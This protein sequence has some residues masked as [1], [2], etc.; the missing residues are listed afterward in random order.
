M[1]K[2]STTTAATANP[3]P[4]P[5]ASRA[6][7]PADTDL[8]LREDIRFLGRLLGDTIREQAGERIFTIVENIRRTAV[9]YRREHDPRSLRTVEKT[10]AALD[11]DAATHVVRAFSYFHHLANVAEDQHQNRRRR[12]GQLA[13]DQPAKPG[14]LTFALQRLRAAQVPTRKMVAF[15]EKACVEPVLTAHPT[16]VQRKSIL[17][18]HRSIGAQLASRD[19]Q[20]GSPALL[21][22]IEREMRREIL[23]LWKTSEV[24]AVKPTVA[25]EIENGLAY[26]RSTFLKVIPKI[27]ADLE[28]ALGRGVNVGPFLRVSSWIGG[29]RDGNPHVTH[30]VTAL[31]LKRQA[32][33]IL[34]H[35]LGE[36]HALG[37]ELSLSSRYADVPPELVALAALSPDRAVTR[38]QEPFRRALIGIYA[39]LAATARRLSAVTPALYGAVGPAEPYASPGE[40][41]SDLDVIGLALSNDGAEL[42]AEGRLRRLRRAAEVFGFHLSSLD[43]RQHSAVHAR[44]VREI[45][46]R[47]IGR[48]TYETLSEPERQQLLLHELGTPRPL[49]SPHITYSNE[50]TE[51]LRTLEVSAGLHQTFGARAVPNYVISMTAGPSD[52]FE[53]ALLLKEAGLLVP[54][55]EPRLAVNIIPLFETIGDLRACGGIMDQLFSCPLY[56]Q[57]LE[58]R[59]DIQEVMLGYS[60]SNK[61]GGF[62]TSN[63]ELYK[64]EM[65]LVDVFEK[66]GV[67]IRLFHGRGG[68]VGRGGG[69]SYYAVRAQPRGSVNGQLRLTEQGE[70]IASKYAD[71]VVGYRNLE[72]L[73]AA[74]IEATLLDSGSPAADETAFYEAMEEMSAH[75]FSEYRDLVYETPGFIKYFREATPINEISHLNIGSRPSSRKSSDRIEDLR[76]IPWVFSWGQC[77]QS[78]PGWY[79]FGTAVNRY[80]AGQGQGQ[81]KDRKRRLAFLRAMYAR[82][83]FFRTLVDKLD[84]VLAK[85]DMAIASRYAALVG[86]KKLRAAIFGRIEAEHEATL[87]AFFA[88][89][90]AKTLLQDNRSLAYSLR[91]RIPYI[92]P[93]N[94]LQVDLLRRLRSQDGNNDEL[95][96]AVHLTINGVAAG[97]RNSG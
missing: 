32:A 2:R 43:L 7:K 74:T 52:V 56:R 23:I 79:G 6:P 9:T 65:S 27:Y 70:V 72:A 48:D 67:G 92:D 4:K 8:A 61:D 59:D 10:I 88:I 22:E 49:V 71:P 20:A 29:D 12:A 96:R 82:W 64:A 40:L 78:I 33:L 90:G 55:Q 37:S 24:R 53:V 41:I 35:Y 13:P 36:V 89:S 38:E 86:D 3:N 87:K 30:D 34:E 58:S 31:A 50:T 28:Q 81:G 45:L 15:F 75:A 62:L 54:G 25:D 94:H 16:E 1:K 97:L 39:R 14:S 84:M 60:D 51:L 57:L 26:F 83:P 5:K 76:A 46:A 66:H 91:N 21:A 17:D 80:L 93:L 18:R 44:V 95:R 73:V 69:P 11:Q 85:T 47:A 77:R 19:R 63:W 42:V 68:T